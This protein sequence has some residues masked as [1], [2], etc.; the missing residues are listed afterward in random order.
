MYCPWYLG[1]D[2]RVPFRSEL[3]AGFSLL[4]IVSSFLR[5]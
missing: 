3:F 1:R 2:D 4:G 5:D